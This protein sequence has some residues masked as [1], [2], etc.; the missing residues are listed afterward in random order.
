MNT[1]TLVAG[2]LPKNWAAGTG[3][4]PCL[5]S[6]LNPRKTS[7]MARGPLRESLPLPTD[8]SIDWAV[9]LSMVASFR[10]T[11]STAHYSLGRSGGLFMMTYEIFGFS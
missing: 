4:N 1:A 5:R 6:N 9:P 8:C 11:I 2:P 7:V 3:T 10:L